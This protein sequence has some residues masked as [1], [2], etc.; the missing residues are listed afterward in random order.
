MQYNGTIGNL[1]TDLALRNFLMEAQTL[2]MMIGDGTYYNADSLWSKISAKAN[3]QQK[4]DDAYPFIEKCV[5]MI[6]EYDWNKQQEELIDAYP[7]GF[8]NLSDEEIVSLYQILRDKGFE[9]QDI[10]DFGLHSPAIDAA[11]DAFLKKEIEEQK[12]EIEEQEK[13]VNR[14]GLYTVLVF[15]VIAIVMFLVAN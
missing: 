4:V 3:E 1:I 12:K 10:I 13:I 8:E 9:K 14:K 5:Q 2:K 15:A 11:I 7:Q 6:L